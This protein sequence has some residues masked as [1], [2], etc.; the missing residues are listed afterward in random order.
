MTLD[1]S[2]DKFN[3][4]VQAQIDETLQSM[5]QAGEDVQLD[6]KINSISYLI[7]IDKESFQTTKVDVTVDMD[8]EAEGESINMNQDMKTDFSNF[9]G[10][11]KIE[12]PQEVIDSAITI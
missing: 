4:L 9:N 7:H 2:G 5:A 1:A 6:V 8:M 11:E 12:I 3:E 10:V